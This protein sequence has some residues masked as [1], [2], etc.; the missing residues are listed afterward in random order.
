MFAE[1][2]KIGNFYSYLKATKENEIVI[3]TTLI[4]GGWCDIE[5]D[6]QS[7]GFSISRVMTPEYLSR[8]EFAECYKLIRT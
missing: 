8:H 3:R 7:A 6:A 5:S 2:K 4:E 1:T